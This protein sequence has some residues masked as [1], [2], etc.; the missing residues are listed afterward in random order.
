[1]KGL[2][3]TE[4]SENEIIW[5]KNEFQSSTSITSKYILNAT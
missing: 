3:R 5:Q 2:T 4:D 1:M